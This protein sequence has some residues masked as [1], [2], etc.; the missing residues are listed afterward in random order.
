MPSLR[1]PYGEK[2][3]SCHTAIIFVH[4]FD[5]LRYGFLLS[6]DAI[7]G[8]TEPFLLSHFTLDNVLMFWHMVYMH[9]T[10]FD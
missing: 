2:P 4:L 1:R 7:A 10:H 5:T 6:M 3:T 9:G 8:W